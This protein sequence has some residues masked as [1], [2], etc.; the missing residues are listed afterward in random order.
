MVTR[1]N[2]VASMASLKAAYDL[3]DFK[4]LTASRVARMSICWVEEKPPSTT[5]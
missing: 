2:T 1:D 5:G 4:R 3:M